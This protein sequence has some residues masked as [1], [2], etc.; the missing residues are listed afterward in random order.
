MK[1]IGIIM[2][3]FG[4]AAFRAML[5]MYSAAQLSKM[6][7]RAQK[8]ESKQRWRREQIEGEMLRRRWL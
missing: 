2:R 1:N 5:P 3:E 7:D 6:L 8:C 4:H